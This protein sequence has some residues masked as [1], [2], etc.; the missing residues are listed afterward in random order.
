MLYSVR[1]KNRKKIHMALTAV[2]LSCLLLAQGCGNGA[3]TQADIPETQQEASPGTPP[4]QGVSAEDAAARDVSAGDTAGQDVSTGDAAAQDVSAGDAAGQNVPGQTASS[5][6]TTGQKTTEKK[7]GKTDTSDTAPADSSTQDPAE[8]A[9]A[10][11]AGKNVSAASGALSVSGTTL[12]DSSGNA[13]QLRGI[14]TH[15]LAWFPDYVNEDCFRQ[16]RDEWNVNVIRLA[17]YTAEYGGYCS[18]GDRE[19][20]KQLIQNGVAYATSLNM[21]VIIDWHILS[22]GNPNTHKEEAK[23]FFAEMAQLY[24]DQTNVLYEIC[25]EPNGGTSW[26]EIKSYAEEVIPVIR[27]YDEDAVIIVG[28]PNWSQY[29][30]QAAADP[31]SGY[32]NIMYSLHFYAATHKDSLRNTMTAAIDAGLPV[33][34]TE[35]GICDASGSGSIDEAQAGRWI[36]VMDEYGVSYVAWNLSNKNETSAIL[37]NGCSK[38]SGFTG[39]DLSAAGKW[40]Y[41]MLTGKSVGSL[42]P[43]QAGSDSGSADFTGS[44]PANGTVSFTASLVNSWESD[45]RSFYQ[46][47]LTVS[48]TS[49]TACSSWS[50]DVVFS[51]T[52]ALSDGWN[53]NYTADGR[54]LHITCKDYNGGIP[55]GGSTGNVGFIVSGPSGLKITE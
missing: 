34:V 3:D 38:T 20:L 5:G 43:P 27:A 40:L 6:D 22:D 13:V 26:S 10:Q 31:I 21:Y 15:G 16:L 25:N 54:I 41:Q 32:D 48:N 4:A 37:A 39:D 55:A 8:P 23:D 50:V 29:V 12:T 28:T 2:L 19:N 30:D 51:D 45:G 49:G 42:A 24:A 36:S 9:S 52:I 14:S 11:A 35:Y 47:D 7:N 17:M 53:G 44:S 33:F 18:G 46:Y 1:R